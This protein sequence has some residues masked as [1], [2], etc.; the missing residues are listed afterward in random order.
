MSEVEREYRTIFRGIMSDKT[1]MSTIYR[2][3]KLRPKVIQRALDQT[4]AR[5]VLSGHYL[6]G[7]N[8][9]KRKI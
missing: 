2:Y 9:M 5:D 3:T 6:P 4:G 1:P 7:R 8:V